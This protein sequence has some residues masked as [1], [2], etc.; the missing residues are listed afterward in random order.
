MVG[1]GRS[2]GL[3][4]SGFMLAWSLRATWL[5]SIDEAIGSEGGRLAYSALVKLALWVLPAFAFAARVRGAPPL[6]YL[7][8]AAWPRAPEWRRAGVVIFVYLAAVAV[9]EWAV[10]AR[11]PS[12]GHYLSIN[13]SLAMATLVAT[14]VTEEVLF[15]GL[16]LQELAQLAAWPA[17]IALTSLAFVAVHLPHWLWREGP[18]LAIAARCAGL[19]VFSAFAGSLYGSS[20]SVW[21]CVALHMANNALAAGWA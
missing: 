16:I 17:A 5:Y 1:A 11:L 3:F 18:N 8:I 7:G 13:P 15:R 9:F 12:T 10:N 2:L 21:P 20:R 4:L 19:F 6:R 14:P